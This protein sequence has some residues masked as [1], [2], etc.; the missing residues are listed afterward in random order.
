MAEEE[1]E[2]DNQKK[3]DKEAKKS[4]KAGGEDDD[5][6]EGGNLKLYIIIGVVVVLLLAAG[7]FFM[8]SG[9]EKN[10][11]ERMAEGEGD[12][13]PKLAFYVPLDADTL[14]P[15]YDK[16][17]GVHHLKVK[18]V[19]LVRDKDAAE[20]I[21]KHISL[22]ASAAITDIENTKYKS[23]KTLKG[24]RMLRRKIL[25]R[26]KRLYPAYGVHVD[27]VL[28]TKFLMD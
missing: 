1:A 19:L 24:K 10:I 5:D 9:D 11:T 20:R 12:F 4:A 3:E 13:E 28:F 23:L 18:I 26:V 8:F 27:E 14:V 2:K 15:F 6:E 25:K 21:K 16:S 17:G 22:L 7:A